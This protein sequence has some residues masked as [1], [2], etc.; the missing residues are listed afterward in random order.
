MQIVC[1]GHNEML[2][3]T[4]RWILERQFRVETAKAPEEFKHLV[5]QSPIDLA[6][7]CHT[8]PPEE[9]EAAVALLATQAPKIK[10]LS[11]APSAGRL[12]PRTETALAT[13][14]TK[15]NTAVTRDGSPKDLLR[16]VRLLLEAGS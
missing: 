10:L 12:S 6:V 7:L 11:L 15:L 5:T 4:R 1:Y 16:S 13:A 14:S 3:K 9:Y 2:L 8:L